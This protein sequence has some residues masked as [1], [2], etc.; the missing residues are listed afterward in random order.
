MANLH[1][2]IWKD[3][4]GYEGLYKV[5]NQGRVS[6]LG[7]SIIQTR[8][9]ALKSYPAK[10]MKAT[11]EPSG[12]YAITLYRQGAHKRVKV[13]TLVG[14]SF[15][16]NHDSLPVINHINGVKT[17]NRAE[18]LEWCTIAHNNRHSIKMGLT[19]PHDFKPRPVMQF[20]KSGEFIRRWD[21]V[22]AAARGVNSSI[23]NMSTVCRVGSGRKTLKG[24][25]WEY[26]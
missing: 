20:S 21:S 18:N 16:D 19:K 10:I 13:H 22:T 3:V 7:R 15:I 4:A 11:I 5:S 26:A 9:N 2:E 25:R 23:G 1:Q 17:D 12:Y 24:Y 6:T 8:G 14:K